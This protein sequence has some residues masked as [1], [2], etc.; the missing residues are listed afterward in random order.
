MT[1]TTE[2]Q[3]GVIHIIGRAKQ[4][5][6][7]IGNYEEHF[8]NE[9]FDYTVRLSNGRIVVPR[10]MAQDQEA[11]PSS[12]DEKHIQSVAANFKNDNPRLNIHNTSNKEE[13][14][15]SKKKGF[16]KKLFSIFG[17]K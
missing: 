3:N 1:R 9:R 5:D 10:S 2:N 16:W 11:Q 4:Y 17:I 13:I 12:I 7:E 8:I 6:P 14:S 15:M